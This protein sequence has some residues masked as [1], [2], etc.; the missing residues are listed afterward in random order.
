[1]KSEIVTLIIGT[2]LGATITFCYGLLDKKIESRKEKKNAMICLKIELS[3]INSYL[4][5]LSNTSSKFG[6]TI[7]STDIPEMDMSVQSDQFKYFDEDLAEQIYDLTTSLRS[8]NKHRVL[9]YALM[10]EQKNPQF[11]SHASV[12]I[13]ELNNSRDIINKLRKKVNFKDIN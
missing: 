3:R 8:A 11:Q 13:F 9:A 5:A 2:V 4:T 10:N 12:F 6:P 1:M 7:P